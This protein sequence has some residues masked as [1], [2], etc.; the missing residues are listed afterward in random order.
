MLIRKA[1]P[2][3]SDKLSHLAY[4]SKS[5]WGYSQDFLKKCKDDLAVTGEYIEQNPVYLIEKDY[6]II[7]FYSFALKN[8][9]LEALFID[10]D[11]IGKGIGKLLWFDLLDKAKEL[12]LK[13]FT[14][15]S[16][17]Y[18]EGF[19]LKMGANKIGYTSSTVFPNR[20]LPLMKVKVI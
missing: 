1:K 7:G 2:E 18:A 12:N 16:E 3:D 8:K 5:Y 4:K 15:E 20:N 17:P 9:Q 6:K 14:L 19:Y 13:E 11:Y 10:P